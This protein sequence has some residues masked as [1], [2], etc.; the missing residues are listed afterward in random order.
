[1][2]SVLFIIVA[3]IAYIIIPAIEKNNNDSFD[4]QGHYLVIIVGLLPI[5]VLSIIILVKKKSIRH[6]LI[7]DAMYCIILLCAT[8]INN[9]TSLILNSIRA[10][11]EP[12]ITER[13]SDTFLESSIVWL[14]LLMIQSILVLVIASILFVYNR[15]SRNK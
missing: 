14:M 3:I 15:L 4:T 11:N 9:G 2:F 7:P 13:I 8:R 1:M 10:S 5:I 6:L 12:V